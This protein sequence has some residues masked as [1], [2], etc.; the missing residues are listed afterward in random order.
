MTLN[1][2]NRRIGVLVALAAWLFALAWTSVHACEFA[3]PV[4]HEDCWP[5][6]SIDAQCSAHCVLGGQAPAASSP[7]IAQAALV[8]PVLRVAALVPIFV[9]HPP[10]DARGAP[11]P[12][13]ILF[14]RL[15]I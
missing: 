5:T 2:L 9:A 10:P 11:P 14:L 7:D 15:R 13:T 1:R 4:Q 8:A 12:L 3:V 6:P